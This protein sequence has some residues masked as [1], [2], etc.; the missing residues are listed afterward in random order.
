VPI[1]VLGS[2]LNLF[3]FSFFF[4]AFYSCVCSFQQL[5][6][7]WQGWTGGEAGLRLNE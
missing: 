7:D 3:F 1:A 2:E 4:V 5:A 6:V